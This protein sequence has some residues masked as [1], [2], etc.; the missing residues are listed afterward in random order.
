MMI[1]IATV[2]GL[3]FNYLFNGTVGVLAAMAYVSYSLLKRTL[4][5]KKLNL[6]LKQINSGK[7]HYDISDYKEGELSILRSELSKTTLMLQT[8]NEKLIQQQEFLYES[9]SDISHQLKTPLTGMTLMNE[10]LLSKVDGDSKEFVLESQS[11]VERLEWLVVSLLKLIQ[12]EAESIVL[13]REPVHSR[14]L[15]E[16]ALHHISLDKEVNIIGDD[17]LIH[18]DF[19]WTQEALIN[20][21]NNKNRYADKVI[22][23]ETSRNRL[24]TMIRIS[25]DGSEI[26]ISEREKL[27]ERFYKGEQASSESVGI[28]LALSKEIIVQQGF[29]IF[30]EDKNTFVIVMNDETVTSD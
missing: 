2:M 12:L 28:G 29:H 7:S 21:L 4:E 6:Y 11:Q 20:I 15:I 24:N 8:T 1:L 13:T 26:K 9:L 27:F 23:I 3:V 10:V 18:C 19:Q 17:V 22:T 30:I 5:I 25:D 16:S 14:K